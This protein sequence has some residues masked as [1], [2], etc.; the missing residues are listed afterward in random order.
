MLDFIQKFFSSDGFMPHGHCYLW[1]PGIVWLHVVS[2]ALIALAYYS[3]PITLV[4]FVRRRRDLDF[5]WMFVC[6]AV[7]ILACGTSHLTEIWNVW[8]GNYWLSGAV[9]AVTAAASIVTAIL[10]TRLMPHALALPSPAMLAGANARLEEEVGM[11]RRAQ[12]SLSGVNADLERRV[13][14]RTAELEAANAH[15]QLQIQERKQMEV[16]LQDS[17]KE[18]ID[19]KAALDEHAIVAVTDAR[20]KITSVNDK[21]CAISQYSRAELL[22]QDHRLI[23]SGFHPREFFQEFWQTISSGRVWHGEIKNRA[24]D[25]T[26]YWVDT[27]IVPFL[28]EQGKPRQYVAIRADITERKQAEEALRESE[29]RFRTMADTMPHL[30]WTAQADGA[31]NWYNQRWYEYTGTTPEQMEGGGWHSVH[32]PEVLPAVLERWQSSIARGVAFEMEFPLRGADGQYRKFLTRGQPMKDAAGR[33]VEWFGTNTDVDVFQRMNEALKASEVRYR[34]LFE[35][36]KDGIL[37]LDAETGMVADVNPYLIA[38][39]GF[40]YEEFRGKAIWEL[41]FFRDVVENA[42]NFSVLQDKEFIRYENLP[43][44]TADGKQVDVEFISNVYLVNDKKVIQCN[45]RDQTARVHAEAAVRQL[46]ASLELRV[47]ERTAQLEMANKELE[48][49]SYSVSHDLRAPLRA[50]DG[51]SQAVLED[52]GPQLPPEGQRY[53]QTIRAGAQKMGALIDDLLTFSRLSRAPLKKNIIDMGK[54]VRGV[55]DTPGLQPAGRHLD[56][57]IGELPACE[58]DP[59]LLWQVWINLLSNAFKYSQKRA[60]AVVEIGCEAKP[61]GTVYFVRDN[62]TG[63]DMRYADKLFGVFQRLHRAEDYEGTGVGLAIVQRIIHRHGGRIWADA[64]V[65]RGATFYF[66]LEGGT[67][68]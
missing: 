52:F 57:R 5:R 21:F 13:Q 51:Y 43:L 17:L 14:E 2:D 59:A 29:E 60:A 47:I 35:S 3:I 23:N 26:F 49:F 30:A 45:I 38:M 4:W 33:V 37:I 1:T 36:A 66:T 48:A 63:F 56:L 34:R 22:G 65:D 46:N 67:R 53:L 39:L 19:L 42:E 32:D 27:T 58:G 64:A 40:S 24:K 8:H 16:V 41:G 55:L 61:E 10:L 68:P 50:V 12:E 28:D 15:L 18:V 54:M 31:I 9:K 20:G 44:K 11:R 7:F 6:F 25:G 62:G